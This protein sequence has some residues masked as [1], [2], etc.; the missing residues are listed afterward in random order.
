[1]EPRIAREHP[2]G[3]TGLKPDSLTDQANNS[4]DQKFAQLLDSTMQPALDPGE[5]NMPGNPSTGPLP[6]A[7]QQSAALRAAM[8]EAKLPLQTGNSV[9]QSLHE[10]A[11]RLERMT[12]EG[13]AQQRER[14][15]DTLKGMWGNSFDG[16]VQRLQGFV[17]DMASRHPSVGEIAPLINLSTTALMSLSDLVEHRSARR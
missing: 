7:Q 16:R 1:M 10:Q 3:L 6:E 13:V 9:A 2:A 8:F 12:P 5:Y 17:Q 14:T 4:Q 15:Y 11:M